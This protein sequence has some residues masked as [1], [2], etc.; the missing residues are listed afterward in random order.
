MSFT[1][2]L[3]LSAR[4]SSPERW[5]A[6]DPA[7][8]LSLRS[9]MALSSCPEVVL[10]ALRQ[11]IQ[12]RHHRNWRFSAAWVFG[13]N[14]WEPLS[15]QL[16]AQLLLNHASEKSSAEFCSSKTCR[17]KDPE[18]ISGGKHGLWE[19]DLSRALLS[20][21]FHLSAQWWQLQLWHD[22]AHTQSPWQCTSP[23]PRPQLH[24]I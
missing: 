11:A 22:P 19:E 9:T 8:E 6:L 20:C 21:W 10:L 16:G 14:W 5:S 1:V 7:A 18:Y 15:S 12:Q 23:Q 24:A 17:L 4:V 13:Q 2:L 3:M